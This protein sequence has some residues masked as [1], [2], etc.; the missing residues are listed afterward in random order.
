MVLPTGFDDWDPPDWPEAGPIR[1]LGA[2]I[3]DRPNSSVAQPKVGSEAPDP[4]ADRAA[5]DA[6][7]R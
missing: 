5:Q 1:D 3:R 7:Q 4:P 2:A 6:C